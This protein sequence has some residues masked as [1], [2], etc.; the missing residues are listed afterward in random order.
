MVI[1]EELN[2]FDGVVEL[3]GLF[4][5]MGGLGNLFKVRGFKRLV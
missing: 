2:L 4:D 5:C 1:G 3:G